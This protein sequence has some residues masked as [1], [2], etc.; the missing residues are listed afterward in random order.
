MVVKWRGSCEELG[1]GRNWV[2]GGWRR[3]R[4]TERLTPAREEEEKE[5]D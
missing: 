5:G 1:R 3:R 4:R 2:R